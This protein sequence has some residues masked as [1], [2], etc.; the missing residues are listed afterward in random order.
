MTLAEMYE[1]HK[2]SFAAFADITEATYQDASVS[3]SQVKARKCVPRDEELAG[4]DSHVGLQT[5]LATFV[6]WDVSLDDAQPKPGGKITW[7]G[8]S[9]WTIVSTKREHFDTQWRCVC[10]QDK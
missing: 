4:V 9:V 2:N 5:T 10:R 1:L 8:G 6:L 3:S 7:P